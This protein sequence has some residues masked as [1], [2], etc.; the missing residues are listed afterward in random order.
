MLYIVKGYE[1]K[2]NKDIIY[3]YIQR[4]MGTKPLYF[5]VMSMFSKIIFPYF[6][7][8]RLDNLIEIELHFYV[9]CKSNKNEVS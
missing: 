7:P 5:Y 4:Y 8:Y 6:Y 2:K 9:Q 3:T 1:R